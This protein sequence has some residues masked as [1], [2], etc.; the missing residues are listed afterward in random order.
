MSEF[1][2]VLKN[3]E[4]ATLTLRSLYDSY[5]YF[6]FKMSKFEEYDLYVGNKDFLVSDRVITFNDKG[7]RALSSFTT[8][9]R[10]LPVSIISSTI[11][12]WYL[13]ISCSKSMVILTAPLETVPL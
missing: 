3:E 12:T 8:S 6:P 1:L 7:L 13:V 2:S 4:R 11:T 5:G 10:V 9:L